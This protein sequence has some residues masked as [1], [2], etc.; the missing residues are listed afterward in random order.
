MLRSVAILLIVQLAVADVDGGQCKLSDKKLKMVSKSFEKKCLKKGFESTLAGCES[1]GDPEKLKKRNIKRCEKN[2]KRLAA[3]GFSCQVDGG[4]S[5]YGDWSSCSAKCGG[6]EQTRERQCNNPAPQKEGADCEGESTETRPCNQQ[7]CPVDGG[8]GDYGEWSECSAKCDGGTQTRSKECNNPAPAHGGAGCKGSATEERDCNTQACATLYRI[9]HTTGKAKYDGG[10]TSGGY[11]F[12]IVGDS[13]ETGEHDCSAD[14]SEG[15]TDSCTIK[16]SA[17]I[18]K[19][20]SMRV[21]NLSDNHWRFEKASVEID[22]V[23]RGRWHG[24]QMIKDYGTGEIVF[25]YIGDKEVEYEITHV[26]GTGRHDG[27]GTT[28]KYLFTFKG[29]NNPFF[30]D[31]YDCDANRAPGATGTCIIRDAAELGKLEQVGIK[32]LSSDTWV[33]KKFVVKVNGVV[34]ATWSGTKSVPDYQSVW[35]DFQ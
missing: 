11:L 16:D 5:D 30:T 33:F 35:V 29:A 14:R 31:Y 12:T 4:W 34:V 17:Q 26:T 1:E 8:W 25:T 22:G 19:V 15:V 28:G 9:T 7:P 27:G 18:G 2:E 20:K 10:V 3:C 21:R 6:G 32:N 13:G 24:S 23:L